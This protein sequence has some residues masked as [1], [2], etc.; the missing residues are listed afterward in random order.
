MKKMLLVGMLGLSSVL[1]AQVVCT[2]TTQQCIEAERKLC[3]SEPAPANFD[4][5]EDQSVA[6]TVLDPT[7]ARFNDVDENGANFNDVEVELRWP[8]SGAVLQSTPSKNGTFDFGKV[9]AGSYRLV[10]V[11]RS[12]SGPERLKGW[13]QAKSLDCKDVTTNCE[14]TVVLTVHGSDDP[15]D[16]CPP[17]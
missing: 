14:I 10:V 13:D 5:P 6:G 9:K 4:L 17:K 8:K 7:G 3:A 15:I 16:F 12:P 1:F 11:K 2:G